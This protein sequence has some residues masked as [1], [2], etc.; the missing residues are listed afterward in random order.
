MKII[1]PMAGRGSRLRPHSLITP[2][3]M[4]SV[5]GTP[6]VKQLIYEIVKVIDKPITDIGFIIGDPAFFGTEIVAYLKELSESLGAKP[7]IFRQDRPLGTGH[8]VMCAEKLLEGQILVAYP[9]TLIRAK[10]TL[11]LEADAVIWVKKVKDPEDYGVVVLDQNKKINNLVEKPKNYISDLAAIGIYYFR[12]A[13]V[14]KSLLKKLVAK[15]LLPGEEYQINHG[16]LAMIQLGAII[17]AVEVKEWM[18]CGNPKVTLKTNSKMLEIKML[19]GEILKDS[20]V[21]LENSTII[22]P[23]FIGQNVKI[24]NSTVGPGVSI[25]KRT[26]IKSCHL[27]NC[28]IQNDSKLENLTLKNAMIGN[29]VYYKG[30]HTFVS[31]GDYSEIR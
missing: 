7:H 18:D 23:C 9:D 20:S 28:I 29:H 16:I 30:N 15:E 17:K 19:E 14:L 2:K 27:K 3:P 1:I 4:M 31:L 21:I 22:Q 8:A 5:A 10:L 6:I 25:G 26:K 24:K 12:K 13:E 11:D